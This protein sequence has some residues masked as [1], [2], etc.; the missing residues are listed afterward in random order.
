MQMDLGPFE[1]FQRQLRHEAKLLHDA[2]PCGR[3]RHTEVK[4]R[5]GMVGQSFH[6]RWECPCGRW[7][8]ISAD[9]GKKVRFSNN[10]NAR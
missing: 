10:S 9:G 1:A 3:W 6:E 8:W 4:I 5:E 7:F 2:K